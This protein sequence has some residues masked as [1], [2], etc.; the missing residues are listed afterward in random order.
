MTWAANDRLKK[1]AVPTKASPMMLRSYY[2]P[3]KHSGRAVRFGE[4]HKREE[5]SVCFR[6]AR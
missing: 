1:K 6:E 2:F 5:L 4:A 3:E